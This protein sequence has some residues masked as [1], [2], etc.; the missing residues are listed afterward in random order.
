VLYEA[1]TFILPPPLSLKATYPRVFTKAL[2]GD[3]RQGH[4][5][6]RLS[7]EEVIDCAWETFKM[8]EA[9]SHIT[10][11]FDYRGSRLIAEAKMAMYMGYSVILLTILLAWMSTLWFL[12]GFLVAYVLIGPVTD[13]RLARFCTLA[14]A[15]VEYLYRGGPPFARSWVAPLWEKMSNGQVA[16]SGGGTAELS[17]GG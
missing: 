13:A 14:I 9:F 6:A 3:R 7:E 16:G 15:C 8:F 10:P 17:A 12:C 11:Q 4:K 1:F 2:L 5:R